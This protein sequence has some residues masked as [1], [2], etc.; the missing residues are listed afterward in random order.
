VTGIKQSRPR[1][2]GDGIM[3]SRRFVVRGLLGSS[4][5]LA[6][7][8]TSVLSDT[9]QEDAFLRAVIAL[10]PPSPRVARRG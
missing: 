4:A 1:H 6:L 2:H 8:A 5:A 9:L 10:R 3:V 7:T